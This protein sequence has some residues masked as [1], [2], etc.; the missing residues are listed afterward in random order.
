ML[1]RQ[2]KTDEA[3]EAKI[4]GAQASGAT[5]GEGEKGAAREELRQR[6]RVLRAS[7]WLGVCVRKLGEKIELG[8][9]DAKIEREEE[10]VRLARGGCDIVT[11]QQC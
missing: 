3:I 1:Q 11:G 10:E 2:R 8:K 4:R 9:C 6:S 5:Q 7:V